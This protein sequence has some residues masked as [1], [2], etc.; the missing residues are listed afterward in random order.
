M[1]LLDDYVGSAATLKETARTLIA[2]GFKGE[3]VPFTI[4]RIRWRLGAAGMI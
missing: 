1:L 2:A 3:I 4:A